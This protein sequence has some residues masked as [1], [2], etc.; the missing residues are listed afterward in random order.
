MIATLAPQLVAGFFGLLA[1]AVVLGLYFY[2]VHVGT[3][4]GR[5][6][7]VGNDDTEFVDTDFPPSAGSANEPA[8]REPTEEISQ[9]ERAW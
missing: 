1:S 6:M 8:K 4:R 3:L 2:C 9:A 7:G 5:E